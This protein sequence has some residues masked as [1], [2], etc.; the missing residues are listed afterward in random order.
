MTTLL[1]LAFLTSLPGWLQALTAILP[2]FSAIGL[3]YGWY[4][5]Y[6]KNKKEDE[7]EAQIQL[8]KEKQ[9][10][11]E[12][13]ARKQ[14]Y[15]RFKEKVEERMTGFNLALEK[16]GDESERRYKELEKETSQIPALRDLLGR[17]ETRMEMNGKT[18]ERMET[19]LDRF[20]E[21]FHK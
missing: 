5:S 15:A 6:R 4:T 1:T 14:D 16:V 7:K 13:E 9:L 8:E 20:L 10:A 19:K 2:I 11:T 17:L 18:T 12:L 3:G 21:S